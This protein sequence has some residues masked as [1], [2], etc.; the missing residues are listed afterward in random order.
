M[1]DERSCKKCKHV[2]GKVG[3]SRFECCFLGVGKCKY[4]FVRHEMGMLPD[5]CKHYAESEPPEPSE[6]ENA[7]REHMQVEP[8]MQADACIRSWEYINERYATRLAHFRAGYDA[9]RHA[10]FEAADQAIAGC[11]RTNIPTH[12]KVIMWRD[13]HEAIRKLNA[14]EQG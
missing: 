12:P 5:I 4:V 6:F 7:F 11:D 1:C 14:K 10:A 2:G 9:G 8:S 13:A 3:T